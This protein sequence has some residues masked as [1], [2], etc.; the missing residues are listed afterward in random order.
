MSLPEMWHKTV[1]SFVSQM[2]ATIIT[3]P[4]Y[5]RV[6]SIGQVKRIVCDTIALLFQ[7]FTPL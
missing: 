5:R 3:S 2:L 7:Y 6:H 1:N 4:E